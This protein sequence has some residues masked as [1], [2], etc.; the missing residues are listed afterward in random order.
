MS[1]VKV[2]WRSA[3]LVN[4]KHFCKNNKDIKLTYK[5]WFKIVYSFNEAFRDEI[6]ET[7]SKQK[8]PGGL[9]HFTVVKKKKKKI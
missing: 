7:G 2:D 1:K 4:Y 9:G 8:F 3:G 5:E 6:L